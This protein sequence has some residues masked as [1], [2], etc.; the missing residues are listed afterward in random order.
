MTNFNPVVEDPPIKEKEYPASMAPLLFPSDGT[1]LIGTVFL[2]AGLGPHPTILLLHGFPGNELNHDIAHAIRRYG[3]NVVVFHYRGA[4]G[5]GGNFSFSNGLE[6]VASAIDFLNSETAKNNYRVD[7]NK[8][9]L[10]GHSF[11][12]FAALLT[13]VKYEQIKNIAFLAGFNFGYFSHFTEQDE[14]IKEATFEGLANG[15]QIFHSSEPLSLYNEILANQNEW[16]LLNL[17]STLKDKNILLVG[18]EYDTV[19][20]LEIHH[21]PLVKSLNESSNNVEERIM[22][23]GHSFSCCRIEL[24]QIVIDWIK[25]TKF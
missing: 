4:W 25:N 19:S 5:S 8:I 1:K 22:K 13:S 24:T 11:G 12:G 10:I 23:S 21:I 18:A 7:K 14:K 20:P 17:N 9:I 2:A 16:N 15:T 3:F 6:D